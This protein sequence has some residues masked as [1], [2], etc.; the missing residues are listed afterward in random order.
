MNNQFKTKVVTLRKAY[1][2]ELNGVLFYVGSN[3]LSA[4]DAVKEILPEMYAKN[5]S[6]YD[7]VSRHF[8]L[9]ENKPFIKFMGVKIVI[10]Y[11]LAN[12]FDDLEQHKKTV[13]EMIKNIQ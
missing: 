11:R 5:F 8:R 12:C 6:S 10:K 4:Y 9:N 13:R 3:V 1:T 2:V 7:S